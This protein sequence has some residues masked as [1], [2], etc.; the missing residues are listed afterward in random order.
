MH[1]GMTIMIRSCVLDLARRK[2]NFFSLIFHQWKYFHDKW[3]GVYW[4]F[5]NGLLPSW[6]RSRSV[7]HKNVPNRHE[8]KWSNIVMRKCSLNSIACGYCLVTC[9]TQSINCKNTGDRSASE[10]RLS[11]CPMR[12]WNLWPNDS[13]SFSIRSSKPLIVR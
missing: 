7:L 9:H 6:T 10:W 5:V 13:H 8:C 11:P 3:A 2:G 1:L 12:C 4:Y